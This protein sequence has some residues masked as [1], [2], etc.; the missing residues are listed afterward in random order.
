MEAEMK[1]QALAVIVLWLAGMSA[2]GI[3]DAQCTDNSTCGIADYCKKAIGEC[4][5][6]G[7]CTERPSMCPLTWDPVCGCDG[8]TYG[9]DCLAAQA[10]VNVD[11]E[12][13]CPPPPCQEN[14]ECGSGDYCAKATGDCFG[15]GACTEQ[16]VACLDIW[17]PVCGCDG[18]TYG[19]ACFAAFDG[20][21]VSTE[22][23]CPPPPCEENAECDSGDYCRKTTGDCLGDGVCS[24][25][26]TVCP[27]V[28]DPVCGCDEITYSNE[29]LANLAGISVA[30]DGECLTS[31]ETDGDCLQ[32]EYCDTAHNGCWQTGA[33]RVQPVICTEEYDPVCGCDETTYDNPCYAAMQ[34]TSVVKDAVCGACPHDSSTDCIFTDGSESAGTGRWSKVVGD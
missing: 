29:C 34:G 27:P 4:D 25:Q 21:N 22:G 16:P 5:G 23:V 10:G 15:D 8:S 31:C 28:W 2:A 12:G 14:A 33:C 20:V 17:D 30:Y 6:S 1:S 18:T 19:N 7:T 32:D 11:F 24:E 13:E 26:P 9:N 3:S